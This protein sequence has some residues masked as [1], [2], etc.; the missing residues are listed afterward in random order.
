LLVLLKCYQRLGY[1]PQP[2]RVPPE[3]TAHVHA[4]AAELVRDRIDSQG[5]RSDRTIRRCRELVRQ[6]TG[7]VRDPDRVRAVAETA[8]RQALQGKDNPADV[9]NVALEALNGQ[10]FELPA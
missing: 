10:G 7:A 5:Q 4:R 9:F 6:R 3:V 8:M 2:D 1:F